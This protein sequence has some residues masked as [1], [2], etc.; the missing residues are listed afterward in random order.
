ME[1]QIAFEL[2][3]KQIEEIVKYNDNVIKTSLIGLLEGL[4][5]IDKDIKQSCHDAL[6][7]KNF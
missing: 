2:A 3:I 6:N 1:Y 5:E 7:I 4:K